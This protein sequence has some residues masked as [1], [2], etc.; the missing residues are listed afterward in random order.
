MKHFLF[1]V[2]DRWSRLKTGCLKIVDMGGFSAPE[3]F[4]KQHIHKAFVKGL[5]PMEAKSTNTHTLRLFG[6][7]L[8]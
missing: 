3:D 7:N 4:S 1:K 2:T 5:T 6:P 8:P